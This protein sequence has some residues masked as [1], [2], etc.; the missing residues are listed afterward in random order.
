MREF[1]SHFF[2]DDTNSNIFALSMFGLFLSLYVQPIA[3]FPVY[4]ESNRGSISL[5]P[6]IYSLHLSIDILTTGNK[7][8]TD[9]SNGI[10]TSRLHNNEW[11]ATCKNDLQ[12][13]F[14]SAIFDK[15]FQFQKVTLF[16]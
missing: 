10:Y 12:G 13:T 4:Y 6:I 8:F 9:F 15:S 11:T 2:F 14:Y 5:L 3:T 16:Q 7:M 1:L